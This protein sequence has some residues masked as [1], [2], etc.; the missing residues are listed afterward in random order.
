MQIKKIIVWDLFGGGQ[1]SVFNS[2]EKN[3]YE[4]LTFD[5]VEP[6]RKNHFKI[7]LSQKNI[8]DI[9]KQFPKPD[10]IVSSPLCQ[11]FSCVLNFKGG[12]TSFW[13]LNKN[14]TKL[15]QRTKKEFEELKS[16][17]TK[18]LKADVQLFI[19]KLGKNCIDNVIDLIKFYK[20]KFFYIENPKSSL[21]WK[22]IKLN[23]KDFFNEE[24]HFLNECSLG[25]YGF[26]TTKPTIF[27]SNIKM[28]L[29]TGRIEPPYFKKKINGIEY[30]VLK[31]DENIKAPVSWNGK[32]L[33]LSTISK[34][35]GIKNPI[36]KNK[37][38]NNQICESDPSS[39]IPK[40]L[41]IKIFNY[42]GI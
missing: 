21:I 9:F 28:E 22:Y 42:F 34:T 33:G 3:K 29:L 20:P 17:F 36:Q 19:K 32:L 5:V 30:L 11:S 7:D 8:I 12:G 13:K 27:L 4:I 1:N 2:L 10:I 38:Q 26:I 31:I 25:K 18:N 23:R 40:E 15:I 6:T 37:M 16:G 14:K 35:T 39:K 41:I 24:L